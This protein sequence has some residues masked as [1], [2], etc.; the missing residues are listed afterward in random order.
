MI[1]K[2]SLGRQHPDLTQYIRVLANVHALPKVHKYKEA[3]ELYLIE[4][5]I[6]VKIHNSK[7]HALL[8][9]LNDIAR[10]YTHLNKWDQAITYHVA[11]LKIQETEFGTE[12]VTVADTL[13]ALSDVYLRAAKP[14]EAY[15]AA[16]RALAIRERK[17][18]ANSAEAKDAR[19]LQSEAKDDAD[20]Q[21][22]GGSGGAAA[23]GGPISPRGFAAEAKRARSSITSASTAA[24]AADDDDEIAIATSSVRGTPTLGGGGG[25]G[26]PLLAKLNASSAGGGSG[27]GSG[28]GGGGGL[29]VPGSGRPN[30][31]LIQSAPQHM[32]IVEMRKHLAAAA[33]G[34]GINALPAGSIDLKSSSPAPL[35]GGHKKSDSITSSS[36]VGLGGLSLPAHGLKLP[37]LSLTPGG[38]VCLICRVGLGYATARSFCAYSFVFVMMMMMI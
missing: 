11:E 30:A 8:P 26:N 32:N 18:G 34:G 5:E 20:M 3:L 24:P 22:A 12:D 35:T 10:M 9:V 4:Y 25:G 15:E 1:M 6:M 36:D 19:D 33:A 16:S 28:G 31:S 23:G 14:K 38:R 21:D 13:V 17:F 2:K 37:P 27:A 7:H 29:S